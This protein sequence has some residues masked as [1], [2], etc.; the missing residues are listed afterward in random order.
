MIHNE[1]HLH[2]CSKEQYYGEAS[3]DEHVADHAVVQH[4]FAEVSPR[5]EIEEVTE[6]VVNL[7]TT[8]M[9]AKKAAST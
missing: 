1:S 5:Y 8:C 6:Q 3:P 7:A 4:D 2:W 9:T